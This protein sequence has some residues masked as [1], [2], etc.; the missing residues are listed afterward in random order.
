[1]IGISRSKSRNIKNDWYF[2]VKSKKVTKNRISGAFRTQSTI[3]SR[4]VAA[5]SLLRLQQTLGSG[6]SACLL[7]SVFT[8]PASGGGGQPASEAVGEDETTSRRYPCATEPAYEKGRQ[9]MIN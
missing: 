1:M 8:T 7:P 3:Q 5:T 6:V 2:S 9:M 4:A